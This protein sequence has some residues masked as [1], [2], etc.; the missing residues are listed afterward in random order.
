MVT[1]LRSGTRLKSLFPAL[2]VLLPGLLMAEENSRPNILLIVADYM[3][4]ADI[5]PFGAKDIKTPSLNKLADEGVRFTSHYAAASSCIPSRAS[6]MSG[7]YPAK[8]LESFEGSRGR[9]LHKKNNAMVTGLSSQEYKTAMIG[10]WHL[11]SEAQFNPN[12]HGFD[13]YLGFDS[14][15][16]GY[17]NHLTSDGDPGLVRNGEVISEPGYLTEKF[18]Q[19]AVQ[20]IRQNRTEPFFIYLSYNTGLP[21]YQKPD[22]EEALWHTGWEANRAK[23]TDYVA[24]VESMDQGIGKVLET[25]RTLNLADNTLVIFTY[26]HGGRHLVDSGPLF[27]GFGTLWEG[28]VR[29]PL[30][31]R[32][33]AKIKPQGVFNQPTIAMDL[34]ATILNAAGSY[35]YTQH[36]DGTDLLAIL[37]QPKGFEERQLFWQLSRMQAVRQGKWKYVK[38]GYSQML[39]DLESDI[40]ERQNLFHRHIDKANELKEALEKWQADLD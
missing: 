14:W 26:D 11:G 16:L 5:E 13:Y 28:G 9:G 23:R 15:T 25:L 36:L 7:K 12:D 8:V 3:G 30:I 2:L 20:F 4:Y 35:E 19:E 31:T 32:W 27:H 40:G 24:M 39:F 22:L 21:P 34:T 33:P 10:K 17:H 18:S 37:K 6:L 29:V 1:F 38:D